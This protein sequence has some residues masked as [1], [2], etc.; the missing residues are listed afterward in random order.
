MTPRKQILLVE[1]DAALRS[2]AEK[3][4]RQAG[5][6]VVSVDSASRAEGILTVSKFD[7]AVVGVRV[8]GDSGAPFYQSWAENSEH[9]GAPFLLL[10]SGTDSAP[11]LP[12][13]AIVR[14]PFA[15]DELLSKVNV[16]TGAGS[17]STA[18]VASPKESASLFGDDAV[19][20]ALDKALGLD[21][22]DVHES[23][24][25]GAVDSSEIQTIS[26]SE[27]LV[28]YDAEITS[29]TSTQ[30]STT[31]TSKIDLAFMQNKLRD[32]A[33]S[34]GQVSDGA[35]L[36]VAPLETA[37]KTSEAPK[38]SP[39]AAPA[40]GDHDYEWFMS[41]MQGGAK[42]SPQSA[43][44]KAAKPAPASDDSVFEWADSSDN[45]QA[46][47]V[48][49]KQMADAVAQRVA[50]KLVKQ[51]NSDKFVQLIKQEMRVYL[52]DHS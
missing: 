45:D 35:K 37:A 40:K 32:M 47:T 6:E 14:C 12:E 3:V 21:Q 23:E 49:S 11:D 31:D 52:K 19:E 50:D 46:A 43:P 25:R 13:E 51:L 15:A 36:D 22:I 8:Q 24:V 2:E 33:A 4:M 1:P 48:F 28:G 38:Q 34:A 27:S 16:F 9:V 10:C 17:G 26:K 39:S 18:T 42:S 7:L 5:Y 30:K 20:G 29:V 41:E 44:Q